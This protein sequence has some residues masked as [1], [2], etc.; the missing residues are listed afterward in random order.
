[1]YE[2]ELPNKVEFTIGVRIFTT[3]IVAA[4]QRSGNIGYETM[5]PRYNEHL[6]ADIGITGLLFPSFF[7]MNVGYSL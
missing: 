6:A 3:L 4:S 7:D 2:S 5:F 1:M